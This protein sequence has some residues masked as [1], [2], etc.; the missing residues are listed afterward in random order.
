MTY[1]TAAGCIELF[2]SE[3][4]DL[5]IANEATIDAAAKLAEKRGLH[6]VASDIGS[7][8]EE[9]QEELQYMMAEFF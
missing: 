8:W 6:H 3:S 9:Y 5:A 4:S 7:R 2:L 1:T